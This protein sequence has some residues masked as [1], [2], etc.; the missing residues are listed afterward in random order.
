MAVRAAQGAYVQAGL[1]PNPSLNYVA[2]EMGNDGAAGLQ[3]GG[4]SQEIVTAGKR[5]FA[6]AAAGHGIEAARWQLEAQQL[7]IL[8][9]VRSRYYEVLVAQRLVQTN[10]ELVRISQQAVEV[11]EKL[12]Q[13][14]EVSLADVL[15]ARIEMEMA[16]L[17]YH[18]ARNRYRAAWQHLVAVVGRPQLEPHPLA[19]TALEELPAIQF[20][21]ILGRLLAQSPVL[22]RARAEVERA[23]CELAAQYAERVPN[24][25]VGSAV[26]Y[27]D[28]AQFTVVDLEVVLPLPLFDRNQ[29]N[30][31]AAQARLTAAQRELGR[32]ELALRTQLAQVFER[33]ANARREVDAYTRSILPAARQSLDL[34]AAGY[35]AGEFSFLALLTAQRTYFG[36]QL[37]YL[38]SLGELWASTVELEGLLLVG[39]LDPVE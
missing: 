17:G 39:G 34:I 11:T 20:E 19:E 38:T 23:R 10:D 36:A 37:E 21:D 9:D 31:L 24:V 15:Q 30:I 32:I 1:Y 12:R 26:K 22:S 7:K 33:Y 3:G 13:A 18:Q 4:V 8:N 27:D 35:R 29:G 28:A 25:E 14:Q 6:R 16:R 5:R 2:D